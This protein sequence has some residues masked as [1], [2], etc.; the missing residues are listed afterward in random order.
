VA[1]HIKADGAGAP[2]SIQPLLVRSLPEAAMKHALK[3]LSVMAGGIFRVRH[4]TDQAVQVR[5]WQF[6]KLCHHKVS[7]LVEGIGFGD[8]G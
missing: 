5:Q 3:D 1:I 4:L 6:F 8:H 2:A 7:H